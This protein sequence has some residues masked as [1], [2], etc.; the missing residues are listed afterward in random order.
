MIIYLA[1]LYI[2]DI[3]DGNLNAL[4]KVL[5]LIILAER[6]VRLRFAHAIRKGLQINPL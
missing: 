1:T 6:C 4:I 5:L 3:T 2:N